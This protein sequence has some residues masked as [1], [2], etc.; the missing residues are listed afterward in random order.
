MDNNVSGTAAKLV[1]V[2]RKDE[3][4]PAAD[5]ARPADRSI[6][7]ATAEQMAEELAFRAREQNDGT[8]IAVFVSGEEGVEAHVFMGPLTQRNVI[9]AWASKLS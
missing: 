4:I 1:P 2:E 9:L 7:E 5:I 6:R 3:R 8:G